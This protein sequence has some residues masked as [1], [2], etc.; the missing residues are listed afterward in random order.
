M[1][2][3]YEYL[4]NEALRI[5]DLKGTVDDIKAGNDLK[6]INRIISCL[7]VNINISLYIQ[8]NI[9]EGIALNRR[10]R[11]EYPEIQNMCDVINNMSPN[12]NENIKS[13]NASISDELKEILRTDQFGIMTGVLIKH[14][15][16]SD[17][18][19]FVQEIT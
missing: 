13:V 1:I 7:E 4:I 3:F 2:I 19:E 16:V 10:L 18:K 5:V 11:E 8:K 12:R 14:N 17:I 15:V 6:E 9:K